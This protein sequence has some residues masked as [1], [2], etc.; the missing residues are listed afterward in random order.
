MN[1]NEIGVDVMNWISSL[2]REIIGER[3]ITH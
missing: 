2:R 1:P 3:S